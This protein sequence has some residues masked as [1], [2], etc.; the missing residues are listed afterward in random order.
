[1]G[2]PIESIKDAGLRQRI[3]AT[4]GAGSGIRHPAGA[5]DERP[6]RPTS[7]PIRQDPKPLLNALE[8]QAFAWLQAAWPSYIFHKQALRFKLANGS[9][10][11]PDLA[12][13]SDTGRIFCFEVKELRG[14]NVDRG[15]L[16]LKSAAYL[17]P[18]VRWHLIWR[19]AK[20]A[21]WH[22]QE[23]LP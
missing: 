17:F 21:S 22:M 11:K 20:G 12:F 19:K 16:A 7:R 3:L 14:K 23:V 13:F 6:A 5:S 15:K 10:Y 1:M 18:E 2:I 9:W 4:I 8:T